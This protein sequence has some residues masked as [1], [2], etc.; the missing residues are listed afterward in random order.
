LHHRIRTSGLVLAGLAVL[1]ILPYLR[2]LTLPFISDDYVQI[3]LARH[4][5]APEGW[6]ELAHDALYRCRTTSLILTYWTDRAFGMYPL[7]FFLTCLALHVVNTWL[8]FAL[9]AW[10]AI[11]WRVAAVAAAFFAVYEGHQEAV[12]WYAALPE[13]LVFTFSLAAFA[14]W[15][16]WLQ[17][18]GRWWLAGTF[19]A[20]LLALGSK[21]PAVVLAALMLLPVWTERPAWRKWLLP[22][23]AAAGMA[24][25]YT[26]FVFAGRQNHL[27]FHDGTFT[28]GAP[29]VKTMAASACRMLWFWGGLSLLV[30]A[31][32]RERQ[33][34]RLLLA[35]GA[36]AAITFLPY[37]FLTYMHR[38]PSRHTYFASAGLS[39]VVGAAFVAF[40]E[41]EKARKWVV[42]A[43]AAIAILHNAGYVWTRKHRQYLERA[44]PV[45]AVVRAA[46]ASSGPV[47][48][49]CFPFPLSAAVAAVI[50]TTGR[51]ASDVRMWSGDISKAPEGVLCLDPRSHRRQQTQPPDE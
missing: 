6:A 36:W 21:E 37:S 38:V 25:A 24:L 18:G 9:G 47:L 39:L 27:F 33:R 34:V 14:C 3:R 45:E 13:L 46:R 30:L 40:A 29:F 5:I 16:Q 15:V 12:V 11:G 48:I 35:A 50:V 32:W 49:H 44:A 31:L 20:Y 28:P 1:A 7:P 23:A 43:V 26:A 8:V 42:A 17:R 2:T 4:F 19:A 10:R 41:R 22:W 51:P